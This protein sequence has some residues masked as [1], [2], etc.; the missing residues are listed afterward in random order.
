MHQHR[1]NT[2]LQ[3]NS[4][5]VAST[6]STAQLKHNDTILE[7]LQLNIATILLD[8]GSDSRLEKLLDHTDYLIVILVVGE[9]IL[10]TFLIGVEGALDGRH[11]RLAGGHGLRDNAEDLGLDVRPL[12]VAAFRHGD[13]VGAVE[14]G[15]D[16]LNIKQFGRKR[17]G[18]RWGEGRARSEVFQECA[19]EAFWEDAGVGDE[20]EGL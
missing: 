6:T 8:S 3:R 10:A 9:R 16:T 5:R 14:N 13:E 7:S 12:R 1:L 4:A 15:C 2:I 17:R 20:L 19:G 11:N 18:V